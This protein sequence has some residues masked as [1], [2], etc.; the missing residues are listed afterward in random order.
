[1]TEQQRF[2][3]NR[4]NADGLGSYSRMVGF[5]LLQNLETK[6]KKKRERKKQSDS[7]LDWAVRQATLP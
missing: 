3:K 2:D 1:M 5:N 6:A 7:S 4:A